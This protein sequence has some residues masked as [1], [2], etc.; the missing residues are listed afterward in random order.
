MIIII[1]NCRLL[2]P[3]RSRTGIHFA[4]RL[5]G[6]VSPVAFGRGIY[7]YIYIYIYMYIYI[8]NIYV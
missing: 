7:I 3:A 5:F 6:I 4:A 1:I 2:R 8:Y